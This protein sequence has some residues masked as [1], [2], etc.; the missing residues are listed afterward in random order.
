[1]PEPGHQVQ[2]GR[3]HVPQ[4]LDPDAAAQVEQAAGVEDGEGTDLLWPDLIRPQHEQVFG[5]Q[6][7]HRHH[8]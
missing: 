1:L 4:G 2:P 3:D 5:G 6:P 8:S 7:V